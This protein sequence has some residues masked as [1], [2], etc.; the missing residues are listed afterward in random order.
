MSASVDL[1]MPALGQSVA[2][3]TV[4]QWL[5]KPG[6]AVK[7]DEGVAVI[8]TDKAE[9]EVPAPVA[10]T[11]TE[12]LVPAGRTVEV[13]T[14]MARLLETDTVPPVPVIAPRRMISPATK[15]RAAE[16]GINLDH[17]VG[18]GPHGVVTLA[19]VEKA[20]AVIKPAPAVDKTQGMRK[21]IAAATRMHPGG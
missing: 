17:I 3:G 20:E 6:D 18:T 4:V 9:A 7:R 21:A 11:L 19:D 10:G 14:V 15:T 12:I 8:S 5:K 1:V 2:E 13:G 16:K